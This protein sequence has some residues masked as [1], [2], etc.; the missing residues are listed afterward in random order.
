MIC[1]MCGK[2]V[3]TTYR[4][5]IEGSILRACEACRRFGKL[6]D[7]LISPAPEAGPPARTAN[8][9]N[10]P[11]GP[12]SRR[13]SE[14]R[15][16]FS[17]VPDMDL[18]DDWGRRIR[19]AREARNWTQEELGKKLNEKKS[20]VLKLESGAFRPPDAT[21]RKVETL[22]KIRLRAEA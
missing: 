9:P 1:E 17:E 20:L 16:L 11:I 3:P 4:I 15:D 21:I 8:A 13:S 18:A 12:R 5:E 19:V 7:P 22:L 14:E 10:V 2:E 6:L